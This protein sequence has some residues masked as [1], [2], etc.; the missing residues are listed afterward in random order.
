MAWSENLR[1][2][3]CKVLNVLP[4]S[5]DELVQTS[6]LISM[7]VQGG[8]RSN[9]CITIKELHKMKKTSL[10]INTSIGPIGNEYVSLFAEI[11]LLR[12]PFIKAGLLPPDNADALVEVTITLL[13]PVA[14]TPSVNV[15]VPSTT[16]LLPLTV[17]PLELLIVRFSTLYPAGVIV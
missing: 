4:G 7:H 15:S 14:I 3:R 11:C 13:D 2:D 9:D 5:K 6:D 12:V 16:K 10:I 1:L 17:T 8:E